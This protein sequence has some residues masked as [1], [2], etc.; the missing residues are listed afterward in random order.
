MTSRK[1]EW[2]ET[3]ETALL[4]SIGILCLTLWLILLQRGGL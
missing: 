2:V 3:L 4:L 1:P